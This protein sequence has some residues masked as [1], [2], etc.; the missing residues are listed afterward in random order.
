MDAKEIEEMARAMQRH[1]RWSCFWSHEEA[2]AL[3]R[4]AYPI[5]RAA[6]LQEAAGIIDDRASHLRSAAAADRSRNNPMGGLWY[7]TRAV[8]ASE[9]AAALLKEAETTGQINKSPVPPTSP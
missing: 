5:A 2:E 7:D 3:C 6:A 9:H 8:E 4:A 1:E